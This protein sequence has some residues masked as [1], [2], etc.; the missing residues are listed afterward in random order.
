MTDQ[1]LLALINIRDGKWHAGVTVGGRNSLPSLVKR[2]FVA[3]STGRNGA[4]HWQ[5]TPEGLK[6]L[7]EFR[8]DIEKVE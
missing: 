3:Q 4:A 8:P 7:K 6:I 2:G 5:I 1:Q